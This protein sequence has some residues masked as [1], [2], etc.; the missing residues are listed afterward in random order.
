MS[1]WEEEILLP[2]LQPV[3]NNNV[4]AAR[5]ENHKSFGKQ[6]TKNRAKIGVF[7]EELLRHKAIIVHFLAAAVRDI[8]GCNII[9]TG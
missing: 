8:N 2:S 7:V 6:R 9:S 4:T 1:Q 3:L 5:K